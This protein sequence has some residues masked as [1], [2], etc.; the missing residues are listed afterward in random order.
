MLCT[1]IL[2]CNFLKH[3]HPVDKEYAK[4]IASTNHVAALIEKCWSTY[5]FYKKIETD[6]VLSVAVVHSHRQYACKHAFNISWIFSNAVFLHTDITKHV[7][8]TGTNSMCF[9]FRMFSL[10][11]WAWHFPNKQIGYKQSDEVQGSFLSK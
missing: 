10:L 3:W 4:T 1:L 2:L 5:I 7:L 11:Y 9:I 6:F 8:V